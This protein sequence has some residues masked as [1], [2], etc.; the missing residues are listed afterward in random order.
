MLTIEQSRVTRQIV[1]R[2]VLP[3]PPNRQIAMLPPLHPAMIM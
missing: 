2:V 1:Q 3:T